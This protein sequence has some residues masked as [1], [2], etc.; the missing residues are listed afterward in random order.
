VQR[1]TV[2][3]NDW[4]KTAF[5]VK[6]QLLV[7]AD[8]KLSR[9]TGKRFKDVVEKCL[10]CLDDDSTWYQVDDRGASEIDVGVEFVE[11]VLLQLQ[12]IVV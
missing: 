8:E 6:K 1:T 11:N 10:T 3:V 12:E 5:A 4:R 2:P 9:H 7:T